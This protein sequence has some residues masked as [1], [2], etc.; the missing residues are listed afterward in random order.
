M[1]QAHILEALTDIKSSMNQK[2]DRIESRILES[3]HESF[4]K[5]DKLDNRMWFLAFAMFSGFGA[6]LGIMAKGFGWI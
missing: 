3:K 5:I 6:L 1:I 4:D 2:F